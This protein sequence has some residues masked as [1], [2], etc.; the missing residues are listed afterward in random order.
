MPAKV[1]CAA[2]AAASARGLLPWSA[3]TSSRSIGPACL[4][5][6]EDG[7]VSSTFD[8]RLPFARNAHATE[9]RP[10]GT[11]N[12]RLRSGRT[13]AAP[14]SNST[15]M[16][17]AASALKHWIAASSCPGSCGSAG[18]S[19]LAAKAAGQRQVGRQLCWQGVNVAIAQ[20]WARAQSTRHVTW[21]HPT[22]PSPRKQQHLHQRTRNVHAISPLGDGQVAPP[23]AVP[24]RLL[25]PQRPPQVQLQRVLLV[26]LLGD[27]HLQGTESRWAGAGIAHQQAFTMQNACYQCTRTSCCCT[28]RQVVGSKPALPC[29][30][31]KP[32]CQSTA[33]PI[34]PTALHPPG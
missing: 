9:R 5:A 23:R 1:E 3:C 2:A 16:A 14:V 6:G 24:A 27:E 17:A 22:C 10:L 11:R 18:G 31:M 21:P 4:S 19:R 33:H 26:G 20:P 28:G 7:G 8:R 12:S 30:E 32:C 29:T 13:R 34:C 15:A 25:P